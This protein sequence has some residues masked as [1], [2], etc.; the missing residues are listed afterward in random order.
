MGAV[1]MTGCRV[2]VQEVTCKSIL[3]RSAIPTVDY[4]VN[5]YTGCQH[6]CVYCYG[7]FM[8]RFTGHAEPWGDFVD[9]KVNAAQVLRRQLRRVK[10]GLVML[11]TV[12]DPYQPLEEE[13]GVTRACL[14]ELLPYDLPVCLLTKSAL[15]LRDI[16]LLKRLK[17]VEVAF[18]ITTLDE[19][20]K[21]IF[22]PRS[23]STRE[24]LA[25][26]AELAAAGIKTWVFFGPM[27]PYFSDAEEG[28]DDMFTEAKKAGAEYILVDR[29]NLYPEV[30][31]RM[32][33]VL[34]GHFPEFLEYY[35]CIREDPEAYS[36]ILRKRV[37]R[38]AENHRICYRI[39][40]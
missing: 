27:L 18:T 31:N 12:T 10:P 36:S 30:W 7:V 37:E 17:G 21:G 38:I 26:L 28:I 2:T 14:M 5:P 39:A 11:S 34:K 9:V 23:S 16:A 19:G 15:V 22:E 3:S 20:V 33:R 32:E 35:R 24:R 1:Q 40:F 25:A 6:G 8:K 13:Y 4:G 29:L